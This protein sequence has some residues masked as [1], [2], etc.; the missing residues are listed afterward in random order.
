MTVIPYTRLISLLD[1]ATLFRRG[2][3]Q[4]SARLRDRILK[5]SVRNKEWTRKE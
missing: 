4:P 1:L 3:I 5:R 2:E